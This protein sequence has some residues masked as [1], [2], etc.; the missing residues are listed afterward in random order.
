MFDTMLTAATL[1][2]MLAVW[3]M[4]DTERFA[5][6]IGLGIALAF[7]VFA[8]GP[9]ILV[10]VLPTALL[11]PL[12]ATGAERRRRVGWTGAGVGMGMRVLEQ[13]QGTG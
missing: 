5:P 6:V 8:K 12:W 3:A 13:E 4:R 7:G 1:L 2:G 9:V 10:H 11:M